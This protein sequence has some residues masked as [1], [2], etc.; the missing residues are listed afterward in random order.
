[1]HITLFFLVKAKPV[2]CEYVEIPTLGDESELQLSTYA[3]ATATPDPRL[4]CGLHRMRLGSGASKECQ[5]FNP[6][7]R[8]GI[9]PT[10]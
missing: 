9:T 3:T 10:S 6:P 5:L 8:P 7:A 2:V 1:M 4:I